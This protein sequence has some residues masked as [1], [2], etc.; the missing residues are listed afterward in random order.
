MKKFSYILVALVTAS[1]LSGCAVAVG[2]GGAIVAD[3]IMEDRNG[4]DGLF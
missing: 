4:G 1:S 2:A 3:E